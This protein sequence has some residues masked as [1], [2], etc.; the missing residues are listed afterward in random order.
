[1][2][3]MDTMFHA[4]RNNTCAVTC[5]TTVGASGFSVDMDGLL[6]LFVLP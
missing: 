4:Y 2:Y 3:P 1:M 5:G 6:K